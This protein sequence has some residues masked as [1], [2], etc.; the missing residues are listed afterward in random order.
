[1]LLKIWL[2]SKVMDRNRCQKKMGVFTSLR[3]IFGGRI[4]LKSFAGFQMSRAYRPYSLPIW[5]LKHE[6]CTGGPAT[7]AGL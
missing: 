1:V 2:L 4:L 6:L 3:I 5:W 7:G